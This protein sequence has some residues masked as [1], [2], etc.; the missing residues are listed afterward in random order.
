MGYDLHITR[1]EYWIDDDGPSI[2]LQEWQNYVAGD[3]DI[4]TDAENPGP[5]NYIVTLQ[6]DRWPL[7]W[8]KRGEVFTKN[9][10]DRLIAKM[11]AIAAKLDAR[12]LGDDEE[13]YGLDPS[14]PTIPT[15]R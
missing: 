11:V 3:P 5:E 4:S 7:W 12:V 15:P 10:D 13:I 2:A 14:D 9:P 8:D 1:R 6:S